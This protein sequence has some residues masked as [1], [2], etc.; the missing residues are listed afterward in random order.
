MWATEITCRFIGFYVESKAGRIFTQDHRQDF[1]EDVFKW[2]QIEPQNGC[3]NRDPYV[4]VYE[5]IPIKTGEYFWSQ[6]KKLKQLE[7][8]S[9]LQMVGF[10]QGVFGTSAVSAA[11]PHRGVLDSG[12][13]SFGG[14]HWLPF[15]RGDLFDDF[16]IEKHREIW[17]LLFWWTKSC[18]TKDD[19]YPVIYRVLY[20]SG[21]AGFQPS[22]VSQKIWP[23][24]LEVIFPPTIAS[25]SLTLQDQW[26]VVCSHEYNLS[27]IWSYFSTLSSKHD[28]SWHKIRTEQSQSCT[29]Y[30][31]TYKDPFHSLHV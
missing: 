23:K 19:D 2:I 4:M 25:S 26:S 21:G 27:I 7:F 10:F 11:S 15:V 12:T 16:N 1:E 31:V 3:F 6:K 18:T 28:R 22:T 30:E 13:N 5:I 20:I 14:T 24:T 29:I 8:F 17:K 9:L